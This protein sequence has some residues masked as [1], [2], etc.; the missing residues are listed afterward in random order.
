MIGE[1]LG[2]RKIN[3]D[4]TLA[5]MSFADTFDLNLIFLGKVWVIFLVHHAQRLVCKMT[6]FMQVFVPNMRGCPLGYAP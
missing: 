1:L 5:R 2:V 6:Q 3:F 4:T